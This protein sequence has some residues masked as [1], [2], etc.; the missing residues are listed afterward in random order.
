M[1]V[2]KTTSAS[3]VVPTVKPEVVTVER[4][5]ERR[6]LDKLQSHPGLNVGSLVVH[7]CP[8]GLCVEGHVILVDPRLNLAGLLAEIDTSTPILNRVMVSAPAITEK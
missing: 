1:D 3:T 7:R 4:E 5:L 6:V 2:R 8:Q